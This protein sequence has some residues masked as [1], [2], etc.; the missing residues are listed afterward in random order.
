MD[1]A[2]ASIAGGDL[3]GYVDASMDMSSAKLSI[4]IASALFRTA[5]E[6]TASTLDMLV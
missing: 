4:G 1:S 5:N 6:T 3:D 2:A